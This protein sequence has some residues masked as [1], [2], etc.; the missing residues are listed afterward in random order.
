[1]VQR[2]SAS[3]LAALFFSRVAFAQ[4]PNLS[5][6]K[7]ADATPVATGTTIG[8]TITVSN[9]NAP[10]TGTAFNV[11]SGVYSAHR[12]ASETEIA[13]DKEGG[14]WELFEKKR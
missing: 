10:I 14:I 3:M 8:L 1:M 4:S 5:F 7:T 12:Q 6:T 11:T 2:V 13:G 9:S